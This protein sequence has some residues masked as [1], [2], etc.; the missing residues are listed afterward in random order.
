MDAPPI[1]VERVTHRRVVG[2]QVQYYFRWHNEKKGTWET[3]HSFGDYG[4]VDHVRGMSLD[5]L[6]TR[7]NELD[8]KAAD[9]EAARAK[10]KRQS[11]KKR[12]TR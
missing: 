2:D 11:R 4:R 3:R 5:K 10:C 7:F 6:T 9:E 8:E 12:R 1:A